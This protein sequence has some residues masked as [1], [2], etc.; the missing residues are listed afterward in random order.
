MHTERD[1]EA[2]LSEAISA[3]VL[4][5]VSTG[6]LSVKTQCLNTIIVICCA[7]AVWKFTYESINSNLPWGSCTFLV[8]EHCFS[9]LK[10]YHHEAKSAQSLHTS[11]RACPSPVQLFWDLRPVMQ[12]S[13]QTNSRWT[14]QATDNSETL[15]WTG[16]VGMCSERCEWGRP[17][18]V[19]LILFMERLASLPF[20]S[21]S[22]SQRCSKPT[23]VITEIIA[24][25]AFPKMLNCLFKH[26]DSNYVSLA[27][28]RR[29]LEFHKFSLVSSF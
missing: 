13:K 4:N 16:V 10:G 11:G 6:K 27:F 15:L 22:N 26:P 2:S 7:Q 25:G 12:D 20:G 18:L 9:S 3:T 24:I 23:D 1:R 8:A 19:T 5:N 29:L 17:V 14:V 21:Q 28:K